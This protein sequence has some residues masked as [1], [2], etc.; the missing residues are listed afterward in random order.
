MLTYL[1]RERKPILYFQDG[2]IKGNEINLHE[3][4]IRPFNRTILELK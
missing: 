1:Y 2:A 4:C 3:L